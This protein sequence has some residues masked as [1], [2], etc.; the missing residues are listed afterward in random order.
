MF[1][2]TRPIFDEIHLERS[3]VVEDSRGLMKHL[4]SVS[5]M[6]LDTLQKLAALGALRTWLS[7]IPETRF[8]A[9]QWEDALS[10]LFQRRLR[11]RSVREA[12]QGAAE[13]DFLHAEK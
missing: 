10:L 5:G 6:D 8:R 4:F 12:Q 7:S 1:A 3:G 11:F 9:A 13:F 2:G